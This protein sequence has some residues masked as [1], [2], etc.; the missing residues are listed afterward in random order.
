MSSFSCPH[1]DTKE[2]FCVRLKTA[3]IPGRKGCVLNKKFEFLVNADE[4]VPKVDSADKLKKKYPRKK[5]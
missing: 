5:S 1:L 4:R 2:S 3:C